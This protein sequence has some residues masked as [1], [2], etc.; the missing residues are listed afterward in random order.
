MKF[1]ILNSFYKKLVIENR[2]T[3]PLF[4]LQL[5]STFVNGVPIIPP[6]FKEFEIVFPLYKGREFAVKTLGIIFISQWNVYKM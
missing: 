3:S 4:W 1:L 5:A 6:F 2:K